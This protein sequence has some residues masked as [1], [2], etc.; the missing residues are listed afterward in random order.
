MHIL[1]VCAALVTA[2]ITQGVPPASAEPVVE[3]VYPAEPIA[4]L[5]SHRFVH[6]RWIWRLAFSPN[7]SAIF[8]V[9]AKQI[10]LW[11]LSTGRTVWKLAPWD[12]SAVL[13]RDGSKAVLAWNDETIG[14]VDA[15]TGRQVAQLTAAK[16]WYGP[17]A[18]SPDGGRVA[19]AGEGQVVLWNVATAKQLNRWKMSRVSCDAMR[20]SPDGH[21]L[22]VAVN[23]AEMH[24]FDVDGDEAAVRLEGV[25]QV[26]TIIP[27]RD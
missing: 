16:S 23:Q 3:Q 12:P 13:S 10:C 11:D 17:L 2:G 5:G 19:V 4:R 7:G 1:T 26:K 14:I 20:F 9:C 6:P 27:A 15:T 25:S 22:A 8:A 24:I 21:R 18:V